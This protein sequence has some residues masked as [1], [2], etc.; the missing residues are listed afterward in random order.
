MKQLL[1]LIVGTVAGA[2]MVLAACPGDGWGNNCVAA[3]NGSC[4]NPGA[5]CGPATDQCTCQDVVGYVQCQC[6]DK[7]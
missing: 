7:V 5:D 2:L 6:L 4:A 3:Q 1:V